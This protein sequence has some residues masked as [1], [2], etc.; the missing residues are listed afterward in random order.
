MTPVRVPLLALAVGVLSIC[1][2]GG[3]GS[4]SGGS[5]SGGSGEAVVRVSARAI[6]RAMVEHRMS[7]MAPEHV[8]PDPPRYKRCI[9]HA[10]TLV[11]LEAGAA[12]AQLRDECA[13][14]YTELRQRALDV[15][16]SAA[17]IV[18][19]AARYG[20]KP[21]AR[22]VQAR[23]RRSGHIPAGAPV[24]DLRLTGEAELAAAALRALVDRRTPPVTEQQL[25]RYYARNSRRYER[26]ERRSFEI[27]EHLPSE[28]AARAVLS[29]AKRRGSLPSTAIHES[30]DRPA[31]LGAVRPE[32]R[33]ALRAIFAAKPH[34]LVGPVLLNGL[35]AVIEVTRVEPRVRTQLHAVRGAIERS[36]GAAQR[37]Q[38]LASFIAA[39][40]ARWRARTQCNPGYVV[41]KC[42]RYAGARSAENR[43]AFD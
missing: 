4:G 40:R 3:C 23:L 8:V 21:P 43:Y 13:Q 36:I 38:A 16:I 37:K 39:W 2:C 12:R 5:G 42:R 6:T 7:L 10:E 14:R 19:E 33:Q 20:L 32:K 17:W 35:Y 34:V 27:V 24:A 41:Q 18:G 30:F 9:A 15:L 26:P 28:R 1:G 29:V 25:A 11:P 22:E 31:D